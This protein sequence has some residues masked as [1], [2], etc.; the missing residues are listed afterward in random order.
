[1]SAD[2][3]IAKNANRP[4]LVAGLSIIVVGGALGIVLFLGLSSSTGGL[5]IPEVYGAVD[6]AVSLL[7]CL[8]PVSSGQAEVRAG[9]LGEMVHGA[10]VPGAVVG[11]SFC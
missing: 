2:L 1:M 7:V 4:V 10:D 11:E 5:P 9:L 6:F 3:S 8:V